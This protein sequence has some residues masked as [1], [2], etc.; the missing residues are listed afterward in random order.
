MTVK[1]SP[2]FRVL[3]RFL[4]E[5]Q[6]ISARALSEK[7][8]LSLSYVSKMENGDVTPTVEVFSKII[9]HLDVSNAELIYLVRILGDTV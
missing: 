8:G 4:R 9:N 2:E 6:D 3:M 1:S 5:R 7:S